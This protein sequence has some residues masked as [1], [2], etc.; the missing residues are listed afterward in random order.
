MKKSEDRLLG[1]DYSVREGGC[2]TLKKKILE[3][4]RYETLFRE[5]EPDTVALERG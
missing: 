5:G 1:E 4:A 3:N 2:E